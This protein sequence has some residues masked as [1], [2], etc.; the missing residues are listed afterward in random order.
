MSLARM[1]KSLEV[2]SQS[3]ETEKAASVLLKTFLR[4]AR[5]LD[6]DDV[7]DSIDNTKKVIDCMATTLSMIEV[8]FKYPER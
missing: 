8:M 5:I 4:L 2:E 3:G 6:T 1:L 7:R